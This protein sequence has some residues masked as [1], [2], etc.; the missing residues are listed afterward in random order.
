MQKLLRISLVA[1]I[2]LPLV[3]HACMCGI[4]SS[5]GGILICRGGIL[6]CPIISYG[7][8]TGAELNL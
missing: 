4:S 5:R 3:R 1:L 6:I 2:A 7:I 8:L